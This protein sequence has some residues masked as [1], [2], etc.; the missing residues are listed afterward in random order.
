VSAVYLELQQYDK[1]IEVCEKAV[2]IGRANRASFENIARALQ[3]LGT[4]Y[5][6][7]GD[8]EKAIEYY[9]SS[10]TE[11]RDPRTLTL[12]HQAEKQLEEKQKTDY[13][14]PELSNK[15]KEEGNEFFKI[16]KFPEAVERYTEAIKRDPDNHVLYT[17]RATAFTKLGAF[18]E[19]IKDCDRCIEL[20]PKFI[21]AYVKKGNVYFVTKQYQKS[22]EIYE[23]A[24]AIDPDNVEIQEAMRKTIE[25]ISKGQDMDS[26]KQNIEKNPELQA[27]LQD[28]IIIQVLN[29]VKQGQPINHYLQD[30]KIASSLEKLMMAGV[31]GRG[32]APSAPSAPG[33]KK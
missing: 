5:M 9:K 2:E 10:Q 22:I 14:N 19:A 13:Y 17:N 33:A 6:K 15:A 7:K 29:A 26:V 32:T 30:P 3:R 25:Q 27:I 8:L 4:A 1:V 11:H 23:Q 12:L 28:P 20:N 24:F 21:K 18:S 16:G 31:L